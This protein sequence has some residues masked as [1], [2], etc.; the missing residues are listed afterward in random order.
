[1]LS[2]N[3]FRQATKPSMT[4]IMLNGA[5][6]NSHAT[7]GS[8]TAADVNT[9]L[10]EITSSLAKEFPDKDS[11]PLTQEKFEAKL[12]FQ[13]AQNG[14]SFYKTNPEQGTK[15]YEDYVHTKEHAVGTADLWRKISIY[16]FVPTLLLVGINTYFIEKEHAEHRKH[17][18]ETPDSELPPEMEFQNLRIKPFFWGDGDKTLFWTDGVNRHV[19]QE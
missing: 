6:F 19:E 9:K 3:L 2:R 15:M 12:K 10:K 17:L 5:R 11:N 1:M 8:M 4:R 16:V 7:A 18:L 14:L 13:L